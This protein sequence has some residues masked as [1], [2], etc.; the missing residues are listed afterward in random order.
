VGELRV[1]APAG[2]ALSIDGKPVE[3]ER[4]KDIP[5]NPGHHVVRAE[6]NGSTTQTE[7]D[8][9]RGET[10]EV[11][12]DLPATPPSA[13]APFKEPGTASGKTSPAPPG[14][15][16]GIIVGGLGASTAFLAL[17]GG[18]MA[19]SAGAN[20]DKIAAAQEAGPNRCLRLS[21]T[22]L[23]AASYEDDMYRFR[24]A[25][26]ASFVVGGVLAAATVGYVVY[27]RQQTEITASAEGIVIK[28][29]W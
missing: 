21:T 25:A 4:G 2:A 19:L 15:H 7:V 29:V 22:C 12:L 1:L 20:E 27:P 3:A 5:V 14:P 24:G 17:G 10:R 26:I 23:K 6:L 18:L 16:V 8:V 11:K 28:G 9:A 13:P